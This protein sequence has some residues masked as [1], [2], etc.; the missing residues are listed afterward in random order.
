MAKVFKVKQIRSLSGLTRKQKEAMRCLGL[1]GI[2]KEVVVKDHP[3]QRG[4]VLK[5]QH[6][7]Q[8]T[9]VN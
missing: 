3:A 9:P 4:Q 7:V 5:V 1:R 2:G 8:V 6:L